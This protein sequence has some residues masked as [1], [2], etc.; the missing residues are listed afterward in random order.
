MRVGEREPG[1]VDEEAGA[2]ALRGADV[3]RSRKH[4][5]HRH[6]SDRERG[7]LLDDRRVIKRR[8]VSQRLVGHHQLQLPR[9]PQARR[10]AASAALA[11]RTPEDAAPA[12]TT[13]ID[14]AAGSSLFASTSG[15]KDV[16]HSAAPAATPTAAATND[17][18]LEIAFSRIRR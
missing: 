8:D 15:G 16:V 7:R 12:L 13:I 10:P 1:G 3:E 11:S 4:A 5:N 6:L 2:E 14:F 9:G 18:S 17:N